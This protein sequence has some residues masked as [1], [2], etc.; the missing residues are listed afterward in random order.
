VVATVTDSDA[1]MGAT[2]HTLEFAHLVRGRSEL[3]VLLLRTPGLLACV[4]LPV[5]HHAAADSAFPGALR[6]Y[7]SVAILNARATSPA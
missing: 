5:T 4:G 7:E 6:C 1:H 2:A 3:R